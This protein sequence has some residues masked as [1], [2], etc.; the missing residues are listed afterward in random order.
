MSGFWDSGYNPHD[1]SPPP[2]TKWVPYGRLPENSEATPAN[3]GDDPREWVTVETAAKRLQ[4]S[5]RTIRERYVPMLR[6]VSKR[7]SKHGISIQRDVC[8][9][10]PIEGYEYEYRWESGPQVERDPY[11]GQRWTPDARLFNPYSNAPVAETNDGEE[12]DTSEDYGLIYERGY[13]PGREPDSRRSVPVLP[14]LL[15]WDELRRLYNRVRGVA[16]MG[17]QEQRHTKRGGGGRFVKNS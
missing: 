11:T 7:Q 14:L 10:E 15:D 16:E 13:D 12:R 2:G 3:P 4:V 5:E 8:I 1:N 9:L 6:S 17:R